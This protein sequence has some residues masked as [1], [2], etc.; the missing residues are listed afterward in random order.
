MKTLLSILTYVSALWSLV[1]F[2]RPARRGAVVLL[3]LPKLLAGALAPILGL[4]GALGASLG[5]ARRD[6][7]LAAAGIVAGGFAA[8]FLKDLAPSADQFAAA[9]GPDWQARLPAYLRPWPLVPR[10]L[11]PDVSSGAVSF[12]RNVVLGRNPGTGRRLLADLWQP[13]VGRARSGLGLIYAHGSGWRVGDKDLGTR[14]FFRRLARQGHVILD[15]AYTLWPGASIPTMISEVNQAVLWL[16]EQ[17]AAYGVDPERIVLMGGSAGGQLVLSTAYAPGE[18]A[19]RPFGGRAG[20]PVRGVIAFYPVADFLEIRERT[21]ESTESVSQPLDRAAIALM[22]R[23]FSLQTGRLGSGGPRPDGWAEPGVEIMIDRI[24]G[25]APGEIPGTYRLL[26]PIYHAGSH[27]PPTLLLQGSDDVFELAPAARRL[28][29]KLQAAGVPSILVEF[30][31]AEHG[32]D[33]VLPRVSPLA[34]AA[35]LDV[36]RFLALLA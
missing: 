27:C 5:L 6:G 34:R 19:F 33:L 32:F 1:P 10:W 13:P 31:H 20:A 9:F 35:T 26:S 30:P 15:V 28:Y 3:W 36:E 18:I 24:L 25:G 22:S 16:R 21:R 17:G 12:Q 23:M 14:Y 4:L 2:W 7:N 8:R 11:Q 29:E